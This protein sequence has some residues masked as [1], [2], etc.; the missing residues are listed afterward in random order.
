M[1]VATVTTIITRLLV[2]EGTK[3]LECKGSCVDADAIR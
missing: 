2:D 3:T 1:A